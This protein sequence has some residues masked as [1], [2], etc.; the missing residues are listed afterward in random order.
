[1]NLVSELDLPA[2]D[3][4]AADFSADRYHQQL[5]EIRQ[6]GAQSLVCRRVIGIDLKRRF[7]V[8]PR[9]LILAG[10]QQ[11]IGEV[12]MRNRILRVLQ[13][14][15]GIDAAG[16]IDRAHFG[17][18]GAKFIQRAEMG[19]PPLQDGDEGEFCVVAPVERRK[20]HGAFDCVCERR[21]AV[22]ILLQE[23]FELLEPRELRQTR[24]PALIPLDN[25]RRNGLA[26]LRAPGCIGFRSPIGTNYTM[27][28][29][30]ARRR[31]LPSVT[32]S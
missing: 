3:Y 17:E 15:F 9:L 16:G 10:A 7:V 27:I 22:G 8:P 19:R 20:Q 21:L 26:Q 4:S 11:Q 18:Q 30:F 31:A 29:R 28:D 2:F 1:M 25:R 23:G 32:N 24:R 14:R 12:D 5:A 6:H 13:D